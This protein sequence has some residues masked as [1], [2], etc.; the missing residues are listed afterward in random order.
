MCK[1]RN[2]G[3][4]PASSMASSCLGC[5]VSLEDRKIKKMSETVIH[6]VERERGREEKK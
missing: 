6:G 2:L 1:N 3:G 4:A 5:K